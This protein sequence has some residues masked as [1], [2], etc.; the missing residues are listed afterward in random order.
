[1]GRYEAAEPYLEQALAMLKRLLGEEHPDVGASLTNLAGL[2]RSMGRYEEALKMYLEAI[3]VQENIMRRT[4][5]FSSEQDRLRYVEQSKRYFYDLLSLIVTNFYDQPEAIEKAFNVVLKRKSLSASALAAQNEALTSGRYPHLQEKYDKLRELN[6]QYIHLTASN[7]TEDKDRKELQRVIDD[8]NKLQKD[9]AK[10]IPEIQ[11]QEQEINSHTVA[12]ILPQGSTFIDLVSSYIWDT[13][14]NEWQPPHYLAF[15]VSAGK[16]DSVKMVDLGEANTINELVGYFRFFILLDAKKNQL[17]FKTLSN[18]GFDDLFPSEEELKRELP[19]YGYA[20]EAAMKLRE[21]ILDPLREHIDGNHLFICPDG[22]LNLV[23]FELLPLDNQEGYL[24][25]E[26]RINYLSGGRDLLR[27]QLQTERP[28]GDPLVI[29]DPDFDLDLSTISETSA[30]KPEKEEVFSPSSQ[31]ATWSFLDAKNLEKAA[32][33]AELAEAVSQQLKVKAFVKKDAWETH[34]TKPNK[35]EDDASEK[36]DAPRIIVIATHGLF[37]PASQK[38]PET[39]KERFQST[40]TRLHNIQS[41]ASEPML[42]SGLA[43]AGAN[44][45]L[46]GKDRSED[47][48]KGFLFALDIAGLDLWTNELT[49]LCACETAMG[50][51][52]LGEGVFGLRRAFAVAGAKTVVMSLW[53]VPSYASALLMQRFFANLKKGIDVKGA[54]QEAQNYIRNITV[55][56]LRQSDLGQKA[57]GDLVRFKDGL[58]EAIELVCKESDKPLAHPIFWGAWICQ[59]QTTTID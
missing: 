10:E 50:D 30:T 46:Q 49:V 7:L 20:P 56:E 33:T 47:A 9:L 45:W 21:L 12:Q 54:L 29:A 6:R 32:G 48:G 25:D 37:L 42:L 41:N 55:A 36:K 8:S 1:M 34:L 15:M 51:I 52:N 2:Y 19:L 5:A 17:I 38:L 3:A 11:L 28:A 43:F 44:Y 39:P 22:A 31:S 35:R 57:L 4:F 58:P 59:G 14:K 16:P 18:S 13:E 53:K 23:P 26:Y 24:L 40:F 27:C